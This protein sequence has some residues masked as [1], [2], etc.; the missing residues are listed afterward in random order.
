MRRKRGTWMRGT[1]R[2]TV[3]LVVGLCVSLALTGC[4]RPDVPDIS[5]EGSE[6]VAKLGG[7]RPV[8]PPTES[9]RLGTVLMADAAIALPRSGAPVHQETSLRITSDLEAAF[10][11]ARR[12]QYSVREAN[13]FA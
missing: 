2:S 9:L 8:Y 12:Q 1:C 4:G 5:S 3:S 13:R 6:S 7:V 10:E 11:A